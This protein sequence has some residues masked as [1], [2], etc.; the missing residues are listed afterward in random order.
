MS[1]KSILVP[2][3]GGAMDAACLAAADPIA[4]QHRAH[5][6]ALFAAAD[7]S[8]IPM[9]MMTDGTGL[10]L[11]GNLVETLQ[12]QVDNRRA[13]AE[14]AFAQW[15]ASCALPSAKRTARSGPSANLLVETGEE[16]QL[17]RTHGVV[18]DLIILPA[19]AAG[20]V[21]RELAL[22]SALFDAGRPVLTLPGPDLPT[23]AADAPIVIAWNGSAEAAHALTGALPFLASASAVT[24]LH[25]GHADRRTLLNPVVTYLGRHGVKAAARGIPDHGDA[26][27]AILAEALRLEAGLL[28]MG[29][30]TH[31]RVRE[32]VFGG[33]TRHVLDQARLRVLAAH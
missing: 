30:Y 33:V 29:A 16:S 27:K 5:V 17:V 23:P 26:G 4:K 25:A 15:Q 12:E 2:L 28:V 31:S 10:A 3:S 24:V 8:A 18:A 6:T 9:A 22:E 13:R 19:P 7:S 14:A 20:E 11:S 1:I 21:E 32:F